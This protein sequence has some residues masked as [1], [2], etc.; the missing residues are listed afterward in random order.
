MSF[1]SP[2]LILARFS[3]EI[4]LGEE[5]LGP[6]H[7]VSVEILAASLQSFYFRKWIE[8]FSPETEEGTE[9]EGNR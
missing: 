6:K 9:I 7:S 8:V 1:A 2:I 4:V 5:I 3:L